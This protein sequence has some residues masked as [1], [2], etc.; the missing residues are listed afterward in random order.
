MRK[1]KVKEKVQRGEPA[2]GSL[3]STG[4]PLAAEIMAHAGFDYLVVDMEHY[5]IDMSDLLNCFYAI[6]TTDTVPFVRVP[7]NDY[8]MLKRVL[9]AGA[10]GVLIPNIKGPE[11]AERAVQACRYA[12]EGFRGVGGMRGQLYGGPDYRQEANK[13]I[14]VALMIEDIE[15]VRRIAEICD[16]HGVDILY[17]GPADLASSMGVPGGSDNSNP[18]HKAAVKQILDT[19]KR[20][21][22]P[23]A[24]HCGSSAELNRRIEEG[25]LVLS[26]GSDVRF[27]SAAAQSAFDQI[28]LPS[29]V[30]RP[31]P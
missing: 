4:N 29:N 25:F 27:L 14:A 17:I 3:L 9:D 23:V 10:Y 28:K 19:G 20:F 2:L 12:P 11:D 16:V 7:G 26:T 8:Q 31:V 21:N 18:D 6:T 30:S 22:I 5:P 13:E 15:A 1:N 24:I